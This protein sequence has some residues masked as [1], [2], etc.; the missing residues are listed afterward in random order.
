VFVFVGYVAGSSS[1]ATQDAGML[2]KACAVCAARTLCRDTQVISGRVVLACTVTPGSE[3]VC[4][5]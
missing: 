4:G 5:Y 2:A 1:F 3:K